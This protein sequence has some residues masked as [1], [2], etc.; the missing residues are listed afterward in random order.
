M[1]HF[2]LIFR[3]P[4]IGEW[5]PSVCVR[6]TRFTRPT[7]RGRWPCSAEKSDKSVRSKSWASFVKWSTRNW[8]NNNRAKLRRIF[9]AVPFFFFHLLLFFLFQFRHFEYKWSWFFAT[10]ALNFGERD[11]R[12]IPIETIGSFCFSRFLFGSRKDTHTQGRRVGK[13]NI[14]FIH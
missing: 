12:T 14:W 8:A 3:V 2:W 10:H 4:D 1:E 13:T 5:K 9:K 7:R 6:K 11:K